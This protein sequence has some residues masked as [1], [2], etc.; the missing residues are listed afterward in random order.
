M[1]FHIRIDRLRRNAYDKKG[2][3]ARSA[4]LAT[5][6]NRLAQQQILPKWLDFNH[7]RRSIH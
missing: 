7:L 3:S 6:G 5:G 2:H 4:A 1:N